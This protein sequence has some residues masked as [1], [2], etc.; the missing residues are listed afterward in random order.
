V[1]ISS[2]AKVSF[3]TTT[4]SAWTVHTSV[5]CMHARTCIYIHTHTA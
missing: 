4:P 3:H 5:W 1:T 2:N